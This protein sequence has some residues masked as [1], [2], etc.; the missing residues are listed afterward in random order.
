M[1]KVLILY[2][3]RFGTTKGI[4]DEIERIIQE[5]G[6]ITESFNL[7]E[8][9]L[10]QIP[11]LDEYDGIIIGTGIKIKRWTKV[12][13]Q[14]VQKRKS[15]LKKRQNTLGFYVCCGEAAKKSNINKAIDNYITLKLQKFGIEPVLIDA[16]GGAYDLTEGSP[17]TG[18][19]RK[20]VISIMK[21]EEGIENPEGELYDYRDWEQIRNFANNFAELMKN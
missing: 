21:E 4:S 13:K 3:T 20:I 8:H 17:I 11:H 15:E 5:K 1:S 9:N 14:F 6:M 7:K 2:G 12:V 18:I 19:T 10:K 16:F